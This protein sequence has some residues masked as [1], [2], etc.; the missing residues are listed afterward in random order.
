VR[1]ILHRPDG[2]VARG[3]GLPPID[4]P[5]RLHMVG[6]TEADSV[7]IVDGAVHL[8]GRKAA[9]GQHR[10]KV[11]DDDDLV[12]DVPTKGKAKLKSEKRPKGSGKP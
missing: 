2:T 11:S 6:E 8:V 4:A 9:P 10:I 3:T 5:G 12:I 1:W 7:A